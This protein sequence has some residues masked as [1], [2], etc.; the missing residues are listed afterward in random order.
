M[1]TQQVSELTNP[2]LGMS[3]VDLA[4]HLLWPI[5]GPRLVRAFHCALFFVLAAGTTAFAVEANGVGALA[6]VG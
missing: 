6:G 1:A 5:G 2:A 4:P 3:G